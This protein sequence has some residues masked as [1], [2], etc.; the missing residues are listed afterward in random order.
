MTE[1][2]ITA[3]GRVEGLR[4]AART[5]AFAL[6]GRNLD[7]RVIGETLHVAT[8]LE[9]SV[10]RAGT[11]LRVAAQLIDARSGYHLWSDEYDR[12]LKDVFAVQDDLARAIVGALQ[13]RL[14]LTRPPSAALVKA[15]TTDLEAHDLYLQGRF[16]WNQRTRSS[17][18]TAVRYFERAIERDSSYAEAYA[19][20]AEAYVVISGFSFSPPREAL[21]KAEA[22][23]LRALALDSS[24]GQAHA[25]LA[26]VRWNYDWDWA[27]A[28]REYRRGIELAPSYATAHQWYAQYLSGVGRPA[29]ALAEMDRALALDPLSRVI[30]TTRG[31]L[32]CQNRR[33]DDGIAQLRRTVDLHPDFPAAHLQLGRCYL[34][35]GMQAEAVA[36]LETGSRISGDPY[37]HLAYAYAASGRRDRALQVVRE[38]TERSRREYVQPYGR[39]VAYVGLDDKTQALTWLERAADARDPVLTWF[40]LTDPLLDPVR[41]DPRFKRLLTRMGLPP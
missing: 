18:P 12:E 26:S 9:G 10:R 11:R 1:E 35:K 22:A 30:A 41:S 21:P 15:P 29:E 17:L 28:E 2:L 16:F 36:E 40:L 7:V 38:I 14:K 6:K 32:L 8:V 4:V 24:L 39:A 37:G 3:L 27:G 34:V 31:S 33:Y 5:S 23:A 25:V 13:A 20:L 19:G